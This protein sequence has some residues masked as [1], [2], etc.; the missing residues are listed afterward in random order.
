MPKPPEKLV[1]RL[2]FAFGLKERGVAINSTTAENAPLC[3]KLK[4]RI[5]GVL[6]GQQE[7]PILFPQTA[8]DPDQVINFALEQGSLQSNIEK[9]ANQMAIDIIIKIQKYLFALGLLE[10]NSSELV[11]KGAMVQA[12]R[13]QE[14]IDVAT[15][16]L[17]SYINSLEPEIREVVLSIAEIDIVLEEV[18]TVAAQIIYEVVISKSLTTQIDE[19]PGEQ[20][21]EAFPLT[22]SQIR[23]IDALLAAPSSTKKATNHFLTEAQK[24]I[25]QAIRDKKW[26]LGRPLRLKDIPALSHTTPANSKKVIGN[27]DSKL[28]TLGLKS[29]MWIEH[30]EK[31]MFRLYETWTVRMAEEIPDDIIEIVRTLEIDEKT[32]GGPTSK[33]VPSTKKSPRSASV[34]VE[35]TA[36]NIEAK[37]VNVENVEATFKRLAEAVISHNPKFTFCHEFLMAV[38]DGKINLNQPI[39]ALSLKKIMGKRV[40]NFGQNIDSLIQALEALPAPFNKVA[41]VKNITP[42]N[43]PPKTRRSYVVELVKNDQIDEV[44]ESNLDLLL[45]SAKF[46]TALDLTPEDLLAFNRTTEL[47]SAN[48]SDDVKLLY[49]LLVK[50]GGFL[51][52]TNNGERHEGRYVSNSEVIKE[53]ATLRAQHPTVIKTNGFTFM[54]ACQQLE[55]FL[56][57]ISAPLRITYKKTGVALCGSECRDFI[58]D[59]LLPKKNVKTPVSPEARVVSSVEIDL[60]PKYQ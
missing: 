21:L 34:D 55:A 5:F 56:D 44:I 48:G 26:S 46:N 59:S 40:N 35:L 54:P 52:I 15:S 24:S 9:R 41:K 28:E 3:H 60:L 32:K 18:P 7:F 42:E 13:A 38:A 30:Q 31:S 43:A 4:N 11:E 20:Q 6:L 17:V 1:E 49:Y 53:L 16:Q 29:I 2:S 47:V 57:N 23:L 37:A 51:K 25:L 39:T 10:K 19:E 36:Q 45:S 50:I 12:E 58:R 14:S 8:A 27:L 33:R 22:D